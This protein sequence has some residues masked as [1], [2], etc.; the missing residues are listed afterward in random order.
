VFSEVWVCFE[1]P[2]SNP[3]PSILVL[4]FMAP[5]VEAAM[6][7]RFGAQIVNG[8]AIIQDVR[9]RARAEYVGLIARI[10]SVPVVAGRTLREALQGP[11]GY[12]RWW[13][14]GLTEKDCV[15]DGDTVYTTILRLMAVQAVKDQYGVERVRVHGAARAFA[16]AMGARRGSAGGAIRDLSRAVVLGLAGRLALIVE[17]LRFWW[18]LRR[19]PS[20]VEHRDILLQSYW[21]WSVRPAGDG[22]LRDRY[23]ANLPAQLASHGLSVGWLASC[24][25]HAEEWQNGRRSRDVV[26][27]S[28]SYRDLTLL[29]RYLAPADIVR[30]ALSVGHALLATRF[31]IDPRF[32]QICRAG[33]FELYPLIRKLLLRAVWGATVCRLQLVATATARACRQLRPKMVLTSFELFMRSRAI[34]AGLRTCEPPVPAWAAQ[35]AGYSCDK[36]LGVYDPNLEVGGAPDGCKLPAPDGIFVMGDLSRRIW[37]SNGL[38]HGRVVQTGGLRYESVRMRSRADRPRRSGASL[39]IAGGMNEAAELDV[40]DAA[41]AATSGFNDVRIYWRDHPNYRFSTRRVFRQFQD[42]ISVTSGTVEEDLEAADLVLFTH[43]GLAEEALIRGIPTWQWL[44]PG[45][46]TSPFLDLPVIP[47]FTS[48][49]GLRRELRSFLDDPASYMPT[50]ETQEHVLG[51]CF[52]PDPAGASARIAGAIDQMLAAEI[53]GHS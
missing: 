32:R 10:G 16:V 44:W 3:P 23:F 20:P 26:G 12:S 48:V 15:W 49:R 4:S 22:S 19:L 6:E 35:H 40:C 2:A 53:G 17:Y 38:G 11:D 46:N 7:S 27:G 29:E 42:T 52:G 9:V 33:G 43:T 47:R 41:V 5:S 13:F 28:Q 24:E 37:E 34:Y 51:Q 45:F 25:P 39:L 8:R 1:P 14:L 36:T 21:D 50:S 30:T 18:L 31:V